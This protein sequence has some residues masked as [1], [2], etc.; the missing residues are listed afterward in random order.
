MVNNGFP[1]IFPR[2]KKQSKDMFFALS[3][4]MV[5]YGCIVNYS[6][7]I[8]T[9]LMST[10]LA[11]GTI[12]PSW[13]GFRLKLTSGDLGEFICRSDIIPSMAPKAFNRLPNVS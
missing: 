3:I 13:V 5:S 8:K 4:L 10:S 1:Q 12:L 2:R 11:L 6:K 7:Y 9:W